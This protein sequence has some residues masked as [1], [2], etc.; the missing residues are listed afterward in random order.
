[1]PAHLPRALREVAEAAPGVDVRLQAAL[2]AWLGA[3]LAGGAD[4]DRM[5]EEL[6]AEA[7]KHLLARFEGK[8]T[9]LARETN[10]NRV[11]L[12]KKLAAAGIRSSEPES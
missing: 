9:V 7:L 10:M 2:A 6:E 3:R 4:Y 5:H 8:P 12:R 11:T 1:M